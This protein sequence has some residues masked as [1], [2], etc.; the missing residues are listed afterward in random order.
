ME[1]YPITAKDGMIWRMGRDHELLPV[2]K[3]EV[4]EA[5]LEHLKALE[6]ATDEVETHPKFPM[7]EYDGEEPKFRGYGEGVA[8]VV[9][10]CQS[11]TFKALQKLV[12]DLKALNTEADYPDPKTFEIDGSY[13]KIDGPY[14]ASTD[15]RGWHSWSA[16]FT[17]Q[18]LLKLAELV[19]AELEE[20][21]ETQ[22]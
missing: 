17:V 8:Q 18:G 1:G 6:K 22:S 11:W 16:P 2:F 15:S 20:R 3:I 7:G 13:Y 12:S 21:A 5:I 10:G 19:K 4:A 9:Y 14:I